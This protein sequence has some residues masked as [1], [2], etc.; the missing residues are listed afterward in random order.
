MGE[1]RYSS[2]ILDLGTRWN[3]VVSFTSRPLYPQGNRVRYSMDRKLRESKY[4]SERCGEE[5]ISPAGNRTLAFQ[6]I[7]GLYID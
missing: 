7:A 2:N 1:W 3:S 6:F 5:F 4:H